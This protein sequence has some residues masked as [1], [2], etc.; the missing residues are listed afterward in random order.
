M[1]AV[2]L[3]KLKLKIYADG[4]DLEA[5][6]SLTSQT[7]VVLS[8]A[9]PFARYGITV[10][11]VA[12]NSLMVTSGPPMSVDSKSVRETE[13]SHARSLRL[14]FLKTSSPSMD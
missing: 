9:G 12:S 3:D 13:I 11:S 7:K 5:L 8:T 14:E 6:R 1:K 2:S 10:S 4:A